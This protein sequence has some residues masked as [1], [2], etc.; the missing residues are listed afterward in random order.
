MDD[1]KVVKVTVNI[2]NGDG[3]VVEEGEA[4]Q[5]EGL[6]WSYTTTAAVTDLETAM[7]N[8]TAQDTPGNRNGLTWRNN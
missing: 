6:W 5:V 3:T 1:T 4:V 7:L 2:Q 8:A